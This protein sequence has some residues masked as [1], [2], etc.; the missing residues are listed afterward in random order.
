M[1]A[2]AY[3]MRNPAHVVLTGL[4]HVLFVGPVTPPLRIPVAHPADWSVFLSNCAAPLRRETTSLPPELDDSLLERMLDDG[5]LLTDNTPTALVSRRHVAMC[6]CPTFHLDPPGGQIGHVVVG[7]T[8][9][10]IA[11][12]VPQTLLSLALTG[13]QKQLDVI[14]TTTARRFLTRDLLEAYG[15]RCWSDG[16]ERQ[17]GLRLP[18][19][20]LAKSAD[21][22]C[23]LP[24]TAHS[25]ESIARSACSDLLSLTTT[26]AKAPVVICPAMNGAMW[27]NPGVQR[28][29]DRLRRDGRHIMEPT[30]LFA[31]ADFEAGAALGYGGHGTLWAGPGMLMRALAAV[32]TTGRDGA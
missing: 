29:A 18:H 28:N 7:C 30:V 1:T 13:F 6:R 5:H 22:I 10:V 21:I 9:S 12:L 8:G 26:A 3:L 19:V 14:L 20:N 17:D 27:S 32:A 15:I 23:V 16:F 25:M 2:G 31:A 11:G 24:A 4:D